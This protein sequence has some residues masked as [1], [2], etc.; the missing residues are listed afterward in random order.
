M[1]PSTI[2]SRRLPR[3]R[4][5]AASF[6]VRLLDADAVANPPLKGFHVA[7]EQLNNR[8]KSEAL[9]FAGRSDREGEIRFQV[10]LQKWAGW[11]P[12]YRPAK[13]RLTVCDIDGDALTTQT[14]R[15]KRDEPI[16]PVKVQTAPYREKL[17]APLDKWRAALRHQ[18]SPAVLGLLGQH[19]I[20]SLSDFQRA[21]DLAESVGLSPADRQELEL[22]RAHADLLLVS[23]D[24]KTN[25]VLIKAGYRNVLDIAAAPLSEFIAGVIP[26]IS[27]AGAI[28]LY[29]GSQR[30]RAILSTIHT[31]RQAKLANGMHTPKG[32]KQPQPCECNCGSAVS[33]QAYLVDLLDYAV[34][35]VL[36]DGA[37]IDLPRL[38]STFSQPFDA[39]PVDC[40]FADKLVRQV[41]LC[42]EVLLQRSNGSSAIDHAIEAHVARA[43][44]ALLRALGTSHRE[45]RLVRSDAEAGARLA[46]RLGT[47]S[48][49]L[50]RFRLESETTD[51]NK[52][53]D[54]K[55]LERLFGL[56]GVARDPLSTGAKFLDEGGQITR[57]QLRGVRWRKNTSATGRIYV[58]VSKQKQDHKVT[59]FRG[60]RRRGIDV[61]AEGTIRTI[62]GEVK[63][64]AKNGSGLAGRFNLNYSKDDFDIYLA[65][66]PEWV[67]RRRNRL[68]A[69]WREADHPAGNF[70]GPKIDP[71]VI[72]ATDIMSRFAEISLPIGSGV[73]LPFQ[74]NPAM[75]RWGSR[76]NSL[77]GRRD[78]LENLNTIGDM[79]ANALSVDPGTLASWDAIANKLRS[80]DPSEVAEGQ[81]GLADLDANLTPATFSF[82]LELRHR[83]ADGREVKA[84]ERG[85]ALD[86]LVNLYKRGLFADWQSEEAD[87][88]LAAPFFLLSGKEP[89]LNP[90]R[91]SAEERADWRAELG[92]NSALPLVDPDIISQSDFAPNAD[93]TPAFTVWFTRS[94]LLGE[95]FAFVG[96]ITSVGKLD[97]AL[98]NGGLLSLGA[99]PLLFHPIGFRSG[100][101]DRIDAALAQGDVLPVRPE[102]YGLTMAELRKLFEVRRHGMNNNVDSGDWEEVHHILVQAE[103][104]RFLYPLWRA[105]ERDGGVFLNPDVFYIPSDALAEFMPLT[106]RSAAFL[107]WRFDPRR[108]RAWRDLLKARIEQDQAVDTELQNAI[109]AAEEAS[110]PAL[111]DDLVAATVS[112]EDAGGTSLEERKRWVMNYLLINAFESGC[113][114]TTRVAQAIETMQLFLWGIHNRQIEDPG[115]S[116]EE[117]S[118]ET[119][120]EEWRALGS[121]ATWRSAVFTFLYPENLLLPELRRG[122]GDAQT[123]PTLLFQA[124][125]KV[126]SGEAS[127]STQ[128]DGDEAEQSTNPLIQQWVNV[129]FGALAD[130]DPTQDSGQRRIFEEL[131]SWRTREVFG[132]SLRNSDPAAVDYL[133]HPTDEDAL[134]WTHIPQ[135]PPD[136]ATDLMIVEWRDYFVV[137]FYEDYQHRNQGA[138]GPTSQT[139]SA[140]ARYLTESALLEDLLYIPLTFALTQ[141]RVGRFEE[142]LYWFSK[143]YDF[144][145]RPMEDDEGWAHGLLERYFKEHQATDSSVYESFD[146]WLDDTLN[147]HRIAA[148][149]TGAYA[150]FLILSIIRCLLDYAD[151]EFS[152]DT[153]ESLARAR[154]LYETARRLLDSERLGKKSGDCEDVIGTLISEVGED[155][156]APTLG[157]GLGGLPD[158]GEENLLTEEQRD[159][160]IDG[161]RDI[162]APTN[163]PT[164]LPEQRQDL[165]D[166][167]SNHFAP[168]APLG[169]EHR[170]LA[171]NQATREAYGLLLEDADV[172]R[173][174]QRV[175]PNS[176]SVTFMS[177]L[178][179]SAG[180]PDE[181]VGWIRAPR[182]EFCIPRNP[183]IGLLRLRFEVNWFK[184]HNCMNLAGQHREVPAYAAPTDT[185][186]GL[187]VADIGGPTALATAARSGPTLYRYRVLIERARLL[188]GMAQQMEA[189]YLS[190]VEK[191]DQESY[192]IRRARQDLG[193]ANANVS[194][195]ELNKQQA[196]IKKGLAVSQYDKVNFMLGH[197]E[198]L[199]DDGLLPSESIALTA[200]RVAAVTQTVTITSGA[201]KGDPAAYA[202]GITQAMSLTSSANSLYAS[203]ERRKQDW[204][205]QR[206]LI[207]QFDLGLADQQVTLAEKDVE[208]AKAQ[209]QI[210]ELGAQNA[211]D[212]VNFLNAK[213][214]NVELYTWMGGVVSGIYRYL[215]QE[216]TTV[217]RLAQRQLAFERQETELAL[218]REDY[219]TYTDTSAV[220][221]GGNGSTER[222]GMT[223]SARLLQDITR[224]DQEAFLT[225]RRKLQ[226]SKTFSLA[227]LDPISFA[228]FSESGVL[229]F[230]TTL[231]QFDRDFPGH[232]LRLIKRVRVSV[233]AL[234]PPADGVHATLTSSGISRVVRGGNAFA[235]VVVQRDPESIAFTAPINATGVFE[236]HEQP[237]MLFPFEGTGVATGWT[238]TLPRAANRLDYASIADVQLTIEYTALEDATYRADVIQILDRTASGERPF[239]FRHG[240]PDC[241][242]DLNNPDLME[243]DRQMR[244]TFE[245]RRSDFP[246]NVSELSLHDVSL[247]VVRRDGFTEPIDVELLFTE[248]GHGGPVG[249]QATT[250]NGLIR[251]TEANGGSWS[252]MLS[253]STRQKQP[254]GKWELNLLKPGLGAADR[255]KLKGW[256]KD[257]DIEDILFVIT[258]GGVTPGW[259]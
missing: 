249:G 55:H 106:Q 143:V 181:R 197:Y 103:K 10:S 30:Q 192:N 68:R 127:P 200:L 100:D 219:W 156:L 220:S 110:L 234:V 123:D 63:L 116:L 126:I 24:A 195:Q 86:V 193:I 164:T 173:A 162:L 114:R 196:D 75:N 139:V 183:L 39:L 46:N 132:P 50:D 210:A 227:L 1:P 199:I 13:V 136:L 259:R 134:W 67:I 159:I 96:R 214:T 81:G 56:Q 145:R 138:S 82:L 6:T 161:V 135:R 141:L 35:N 38:G 128:D 130:L 241:W 133:R 146:D 222:L 62:T 117:A 203:Y 118:A 217:S 53:L 160:F 112:P 211:S 87:I 151:S 65:V 215:L 90:L 189:S 71:D 11:L 223:G 172:F 37:A 216:A 191:R 255:E 19:G 17:I 70:A 107:R 121:Y 185:Y 83:E 176:N 22:M 61:V 115:Y 233:I 29:F 178:A 84:E 27:K 60:A 109:A 177:V 248:S 97:G 122:I 231:A 194:L 74:V 80:S 150:R 137:S 171:G 79:L 125:L 186:S 142:A 77:R 3:D 154:E 57:W 256:F 170:R 44:E 224:L 108:Q 119:F 73:L 23:R 250:T 28:K 85:Q 72:D 41:R 230:S 32:P 105:E 54:E 169:L 98:T 52:Q 257:G 153:S 228:R 175:G 99:A 124:I 69:L 2:N 179:V 7:V 58:S 33:P 238:F 198:D 187:P 51:A 15:P 209:K 246:P 205:F 91:A 163:P 5:D 254:V 180:R 131:P 239:S 8:G 202:E 158:P 34:D 47:T 25:Q 247:Y 253:D 188:V 140:W 206:D 111:R 168:T 16:P 14:I 120:A 204:E 229:T 4:K 94:E 243:A 59:L 212:V 218:I 157:S 144:R 18:S 88:Q 129:I 208:I 244:V 42:A 21:K 12:F 221:R 20:A 92:R 149:R 235:E 190:F 236:L 226:L 43:Y 232:Y 165:I 207:E 104:R 113:R 182:F 147:P 36:V 31:D 251:A 240:L 101:L 49:H 45:L 26:D 9:L 64:V 78:E 148:T 252:R 245:T 76:K 242:Y 225:E 167:V 237:E 40:E 93:S 174:V 166:L 95:V 48:D 102:E 89:V 201:L 258:Y 66:V 184:L 155:A 213:F 152:K